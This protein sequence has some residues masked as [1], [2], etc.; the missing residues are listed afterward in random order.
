MSAHWLESEYDTG[1]VIAQRSLPIAPSWNAWQLARALDRP[2]LEVLRDVVRRLALGES[3]PGIPQDAS[4]ATE[5]PSPTD[6]ELEIDWNWTCA[7]IVSRIRAA[8][9]MPGAFTDLVGHEFVIGD[10]GLLP[11]SRRL[12][13]LSPGEMAIIDGA[14]V[15]RAAD[16][17]IHVRRAS[18][19][20]EDA[21]TGEMLLQRLSP[22]LAA[23]ASAPM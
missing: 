13:P 4:L 3:L 16:G 15:I 8:A 20:D 10:A 9:P 11:L 14:I 17:G 12:A 5:A 21:L 1:R 18:L 19:D 22:F 23:G 6:A 2:S 7:Q